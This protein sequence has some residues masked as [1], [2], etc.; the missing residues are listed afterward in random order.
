MVFHLLSAAYG[1]VW[2]NWER[3][4]NGVWK[5]DL[6][7]HFHDEDGVMLLK[8]VGQRFNHVLY[9]PGRQWQAESSGR[10]Q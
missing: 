9:Y 3:V 5:I 7:L 6:F 10:T 2:D 8:M 1:S 4:G